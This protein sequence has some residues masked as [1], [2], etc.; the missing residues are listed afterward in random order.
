MTIAR[1]KNQTQNKNKLQHAPRGHSPRTATEKCTHK[2]KTDYNIRRRSDLEGK[3][4]TKTDYSRTVTVREKKLKRTIGSALVGGC[5][6]VML[7]VLRC[8]LTG[9]VVTNAKA[10]FSGRLT[11]SLPDD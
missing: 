6:E 7:N 3:T 1:K 10:W 4:K 2:N 5:G 11:A 9:Q 8:Q